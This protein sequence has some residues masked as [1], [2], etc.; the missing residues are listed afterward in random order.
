VKASSTI[1]TSELM[2]RFTLSSLSM[3]T[4]TVLL[5]GCVAAIGNRDAQREHG[6]ATLGQHFLVGSRQL[7]AGSLSPSS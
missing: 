3:L 4:T 2:K 7:A 1:E 6:Y 5:S